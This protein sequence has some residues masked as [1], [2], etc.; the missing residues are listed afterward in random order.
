VKHELAHLREQWVQDTLIARIEG[1]I[2]ASNVFSMGDR[3]RSLLTNRSIAM[4]LDL[5]ATTYLDSA[6]LNLLFALAEEMRA[7]QQRFALVV[8]E[9]SPVRRMIDLTGVGRVTSLHASVDEALRVIRE[10]S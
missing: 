2:D 5:S 8:R 1:E 3:L 7:H 6:G 9:T 10:A 4:V